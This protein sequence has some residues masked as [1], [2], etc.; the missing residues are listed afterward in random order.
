MFSKKSTSQ[1]RPSDARI[2]PDQISPVAAVQNVQAGQPTPAT[3]SPQSQIDDSMVSIGRG[4]VIVGEINE[5]RN[6]EIQGSVEGTISTEMLVIHEGGSVKGRVHASNA[7]VYGVFN[8]QLEVSGLL[9]VRGTGR[10]EGELEYGQLAVAM[11]GHISG[12]VFTGFEREQRNSQASQQTIPLPPSSSSETNYR[13]NL[14]VL[15]GQ[16][17]T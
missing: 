16:S 14:T 4:T 17:P 9:D 13:P 1:V 10:V 7:I 15:N 3:P 8:G 6:L 11:G 5:C 12:S 2:A